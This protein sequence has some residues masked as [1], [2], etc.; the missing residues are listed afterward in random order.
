MRP[1]DDDVMKRYAALMKDGYK[2]FPPVSIVNDGKNLYLYDGYH[3][4]FAHL[5][6]NKKYIE[7]TVES[8]TLRDAQ[9]FSFGANKA[10]GF[11]RQAGTA[12]EIVKKLLRDEEWSKM[13]IRAIADHV[14]CTERY[15]QKIQADLKNEA[16]S[17]EAYGVN[18]SPHK[19]DS[20]PKN[21]LSR[22]ETRNVKRGDSEYE[23]SV[24]E[25]KVLDSTGNQVPEHLV[26]YFE[27]AN[28]YRQMIK[29]LNDQLKTVRDGKEAG[30]LFYRF[31]KIE[32]L[33]AEIGNVKRIYRFAVPYATCPYCGG[34]KNNAE[35]RACDGC[36]F[37]NEKTYKATPGD[38]K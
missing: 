36:G 26:K 38:L 2:G 1:V 14:G 10:N 31:I 24:P 4:F 18:S 3:R 16:N 11:P 35:C 7:A 5:R 13:S 37:V 30:D 9:Y 12:G 23:A 15:V 34:D 19:P 21:Q 25:K 17:D 29:Q 6:L 32:N 8:G 20:K 27:R 28:E 22:A 33:T